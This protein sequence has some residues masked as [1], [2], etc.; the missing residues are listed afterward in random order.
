MMRIDLPVE[1]LDKAIFFFGCSHGYIIDPHP[2]TQTEWKVETPQDK[3]RAFGL[4]AELLS[5]LK[6]AEDEG[7]VGWFT[8]DDET[9]LEHHERW[10]LLNGLLK[11]NGLNTFETEEDKSYNTLAARRLILEANP[12]LCVVY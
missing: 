1:A 9:R 2:G 5:A 3:Q 12:G 11:Q 8:R 6:E 4:N 10:R 7:R